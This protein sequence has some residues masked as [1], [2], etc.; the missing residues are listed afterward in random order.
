MAWAVFLFCSPI[1]GWKG[2]GGPMVD[3]AGFFFRMSD[4]EYEEYDKM[5]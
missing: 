5:I 2:G 1:L 4:I 3:M